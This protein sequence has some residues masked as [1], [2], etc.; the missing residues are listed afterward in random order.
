MIWFSFEGWKSKYYIHFGSR[1]EFKGI[2][3][4]PPTYPLGCACEGAAVWR[5][6][7]LAPPRHSQVLYCGY[8]SWWSRTPP[9]RSVR[10]VRSQRWMHNLRASM[11]VI[12]VEPLFG[13]VEYR[14]Y[15]ASLTGLACRRRRVRWS[16]ITLGQCFSR[17]SNSQCSRFVSGFFR[18]GWVLGPL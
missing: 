4:S 2:C 7:V 9:L 17:W 14:L 8:C 15:P 1:F 12:R 3:F 10:F 16:G 6:P 5:N 11:R 18:D 13:R